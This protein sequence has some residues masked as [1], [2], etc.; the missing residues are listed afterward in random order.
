MANHLRI[1]EDRG[2]LRNGFAAAATKSALTTMSSAISGM[3]QA[4]IM[5]MTM[6]R[7]SSGTADKSASRRMISKDCA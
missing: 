4:W 5:R 7:A 6:W 3:P 1:D 2:P